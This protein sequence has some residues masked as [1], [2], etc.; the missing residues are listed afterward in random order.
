MRYIYRRVFV[1]KSNISAAAGVV[2]VISAD[3]YAPSS[4]VC[5]AHVL[6]LSADPRRNVSPMQHLW[7][8]T[9][10]VLAEECAAASARLMASLNGT[11]DT[12]SAD[13]QSAASD[14]SIEEEA[15]SATGGG[16]DETNT[17][18]GHG[19]V[20]ASIRVMTYNIWH[21]NP[22]AW[23][24]SN[25]MYDTTRMCLCMLYHIMPCHVMSCVDCL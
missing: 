9:G 25:P 1:E 22:A 12:Q 10:G 2:I 19:G 14:S 8:D 18:L 13:T 20:T 15:S 5:R 24:Y 17:D 4:S 7:T 16:K 6:V 21:T 3:E 11:A 23:L